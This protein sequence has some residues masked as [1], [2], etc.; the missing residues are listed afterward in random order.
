MERGVFDRRRTIQLGNVCAGTPAG[1]GEMGFPDT[2]NRH[3]H[4]RAGDG[5]PRD[6]L[7]G[8]G[9][10]SPARTPAGEFSEDQQH[11]WETGISDSSSCQTD[12]HFSPAELQ[13]AL[14]LQRPV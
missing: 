2:G 3:I 4:T 11:K 10:K 8:E 1:Y 6:L 14:F 12:H 5:K 9:T 13:G 7:R